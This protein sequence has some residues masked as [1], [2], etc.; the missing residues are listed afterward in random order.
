MTMKF[1]VVGA[2]HTERG[3]QTGTTENGSPT[4]AEVTYAR[5]EVVETDIDLAKRFNPKG[6]PQMAKFVRLADTSKATYKEFSRF[7]KA[8]DVPEEADASE[9]LAE[10]EVEHVPSDDEHE[11]DEEGGIAEDTLG[12]MTVAELRLHAGSEGI[13]LHGATTKADIIKRIRG[14]Q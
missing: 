5:G 12:S 13:D 2:P 1:K 6:A 4:Y 14:A 3:R 11:P 10:E 9:E 8:G 7:S